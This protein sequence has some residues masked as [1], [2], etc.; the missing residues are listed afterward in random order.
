MAI[1]ASDNGGKNFTPVSAGCHFAICNMIA[2]LGIQNT[3]YNGK[4][5]SVPQIYM[6][7]EVP[8]ERVTYERDGKEIEAPR[9]IGITYTLS[10]SEKANLRKMLENWRGKAFTAEE[11]KGFDVTVVAGKCCQIMVTHTTKPDGSVSAKITGVMGISKDQK[12]R[13]KSAKSEI[14]V[15]VYELDDPDPETHAKLPQWLKDKLAARVPPQSVK[16]VTENA[17]AGDPEFDDA[18]P[19]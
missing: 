1:T 15:M 6:R 3:T 7:F 4:A 9:V 14:G 17:P 13:S 16:T 18:I 8:D 12:E 2:D 5:K 10:L 19:F 11:L